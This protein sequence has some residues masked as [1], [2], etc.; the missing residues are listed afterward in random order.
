[1]LGI[2][3]E[4][5]SLDR[6]PNVPSEDENYI[7]SPV[8]GFTNTNDLV[9]D[10]NYLKKRSEFLFNAIIIADQKPITEEIKTKLKLKERVSKIDNKFIIVIHE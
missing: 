3:R 5:S 7:G 4:V 2:D 8:L 1:M 10:F 6:Y 9:R